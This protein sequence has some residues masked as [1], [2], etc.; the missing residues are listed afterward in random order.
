MQVSCGDRGSAMR[1]THAAMGRGKNVTAKKN[2]SCVR[3]KQSSGIDLEA[4]LLHRSHCNFS[5]T[6]I[7]KR[8]IT[9]TSWEVHDAIT[10]LPRLLCSGD[11]VELRRRSS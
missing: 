5:P 3:Q 7:E 10:N 2:C 6:P 8:R 4:G 9:T 11:V 1:P